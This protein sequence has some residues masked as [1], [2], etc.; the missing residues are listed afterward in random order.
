MAVTFRTMINRVL[1]AV[2][3]DEID[4]TVDEIQDDYHK[5]VATFVNIIREEVEAAT[6]WRSLQQTLPVTVNA[7]ATSAEITGA[8]ERSRLVRVQDAR[9][10]RLVPLVFDVTDTN[11]PQA[12]TELSRPEMIYRQTMESGSTNTSPAYFAIDDSSGDAVNILVH[13]TPSTQRTLAVTMVVPQERM[14]DTDLDTVIKIP[15]TPLELGSIWYALEERGEEL[16]QSNIFTED[17]Y[18]NALDAA[19]SRDVEEQGGLE[20]VPV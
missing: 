13:P 7:S 5:L 19:V 8:N 2:S 3:E 20:M 6:N 9:R 12:L 1:R 14:E 17:R 10:G 15:T 11:N 16:G 18:R 4:D